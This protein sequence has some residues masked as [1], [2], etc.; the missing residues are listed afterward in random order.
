MSETV[1]GDRYVVGFMFNP[2]ENAVLLIRKTHPDWQAGKLN[3]VG[4]RIEDGE[5][6][7]EAMRREFLEETG[8]DHD[9]WREF[10]VLGDARQWQ[11]HFF[12]AV[13]LIAKA[14]ACT[15]EKP[16]IHPSMALPFDTI[17]NLRWLIPMALSM[18]F[19]RIASFSIV[20]VAHQ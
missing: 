14:V 13:G 4:G 1:A 2:A 3:G 20:E 15:D 9:D 18:R 8:I 19:E 6:P 7:T 10:C 16:E 12:S 11:I 17:P 5:S